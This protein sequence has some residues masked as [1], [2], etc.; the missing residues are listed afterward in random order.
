M[1]NAMSPD[2]R[3]RC[4]WAAGDSLLAR[5]HDLEWGVPPGDD[6]AHFEALTLEIFQAGLSWRTVLY[7]REG[8]RRAFAGFSIPAVAAFS[9]D[10]V[11]R[12]LLDPSIVRHRAKIEATVHNARALLALQ[13]EAGSFVDWLAG[14]PAD[15]DAIHAALRPRLAFFGRTTCVS[16]LE[17]NWEDPSCPR[18]GVLARRVTRSDGAS[19]TCVTSRST[20]G[21]RSSV[22]LNLVP[23]NHLP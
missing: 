1:A 17:G 16:F 12:L 20:D 19:G 6:D 21:P 15:P 10:D 14:Q 13:E 7:K 3:V 22:R 11:D 5:Y 9:S 4:R 2:G 8:F 23:A 18:P